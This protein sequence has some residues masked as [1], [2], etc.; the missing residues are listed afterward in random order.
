MTQATVGKWRRRFLA[1]G[2]GG[3]HDE[4]RPG[5]LVISALELIHKS[6]ISLD[7][8]EFRLQLENRLVIGRR[9]LVITRFLGLLG[10]LEEFLDLDVRSRLSSGGFREKEQ[11]KEGQLTN[12]CVHLQCLPIMK[13]RSNEGRL[14]KQTEDAWQEWPLGRVAS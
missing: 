13:G 10:R 8:G 7:L 5:R 2:V 3:L 11:D 4:L 12:S 1:Q 14:K 6:M 9:L